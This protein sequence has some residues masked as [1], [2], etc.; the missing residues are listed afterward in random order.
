MKIIFILLLIAILFLQ[1]RRIESFAD[2]DATFRTRYNEFILFYNQFQANYMKAI[3]T[4]WGLAQPA[5]TEGA[6]A[7]SPTMEQLNAYLPTLIQKEGPLPSVTNPLPSL[8]STDDLMK[9]QAQIPRDPAPFQTALRWMNTSMETNLA[10]LGSSLTALQ[11]FVDINAI[12]GFAKKDYPTMEFFNDICQQIQSCQ[13]SQQQQQEQ[14][15]AT[16]QQELMSVFQSFKTLQPLLD[17]NNDLAA[18]SQKIQDKA[19]NGSLMPKPPTRKSPYTLPPGSNNLKQMQEDN[20]SQYK[21]YQKD[22]GQFVAIKQYSDQI[23]GVLR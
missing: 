9:I 21:Q 20:P 14:K 23:N 13:A 4:S 8:Q 3:T 15:A 19:Q 11:G 18:T 5:P 17:K 12:H 16:I 10:S 2:L 6:A 22:F 1:Y 7:P